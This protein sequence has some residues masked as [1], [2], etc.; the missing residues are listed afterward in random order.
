MAM[1]V[2]AELQKTV[3][4]GGDASYPPFE[5]NE[6]SVPAGFNIDIEN[7]LASVGL[8]RAE[9]K[10]GE[11]PE[12]IQALESG[13]IDVLPMFLSDER[14]KK[15][16]FTSPFYYLNHALYALSDVE[17]IPSIKSLSGQ[18]IAVETLSYAHERLQLEQADPT[19]ILTKDTLAALESVAKGEAV[20]A[21][22]AAPIASRLIV[23]HDLDLHRISPPFWPRGY[24]FAVRNDR[25]ELANWLESSLN[26]T[27]ATG[28]YNEVYQ[29]WKNQLEPS[30]SSRTDFWQ[31]TAIIIIPLLLIAVLGFIWSW[32]LQRT[33]TKRTAEL[34]KEL[35]RRKAAES[36]I[37]HLA[38]HDALTGLPEYHYVVK[39]ANQIFQNSSKE[40]T[41][42][43][44]LVI[45]KLAETEMITR[46][47]GN[48]VEEAFIKAFAERLK[49]FGFDVCGYIGRGVFA[50]V[51]HQNRFRINL[52]ELTAQLNVKGLS[53]YP[54][55]VAGIACW[56]DHS[57]SAEELG[58]K[59]ET[60]LAVSLERNHDWAIYD[61]HME[62]DKIDHQIV[63]EFRKKN[64]TGLYAVLQPQIELKTGQIVAAEALVRWDSPELGTVS[65]GK[66]IPLL[67]KAGLIKQV[68]VRMINEAVRIAVKL[69]KMNQPCPISVNVS[70]NDLQTTDDLPS[71][72][73]AAL[74]RHGGQAGDVKLELTETA[75]AEN[76]DQVRTVLDLLSKMGIYTSIDDFGTGYSSLSYLS[77]YPIQEVKIDQMFVADI[78]HNKRNRSIVRSTIAMAHAL[79]ITVVAEGAEDEETMEILKVEECDR[80]Q[81][82]VIS[83]P[84]PEDSFVDFLISAQK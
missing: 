61:H 38:N 74:A 43:K 71:I 41:P 2:Y 44:E 24:A 83:K 27:I 36:R 35:E 15:F 37:T 3:I 69:R 29:R 58:R 16:L 56:P 55:V 72:F 5:W 48:S 34:R 11:W 25:T 63:T 9:H 42:T 51:S 67:E 65:P 79:G 70:A 54:Q 7:A 8:V 32:M 45:L 31:T 82:F 4:F 20:Y 80:V 18:S 6:N 40:S 57:D 30:N 28:A 66:F 33:V 14:E 77:S 26:L 84:L 78:A 59:A 17:E 75:L 21:V 19:L 23:E 60:A 50:I 81:G 47:F 49:L 62:P 22:L 68:T 12:M 10:L 1:P 76:P 13:T 64:G 53:L 52:D 73:H 46:V 39:L